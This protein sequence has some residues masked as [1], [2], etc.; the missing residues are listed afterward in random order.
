MPME[1]VVAAVLLGVALLT[2]L[3][4]I[5]VPGPVRLAP[6]RRRPVG[7][8]PPGVLTQVAEAT[9]NQVGALLR[10]RGRG[11]AALFER[12]G[13]RSRPQDVII[14]VACCTLVA[15]AA[16]LLLVHPLFGL[17]LA[18][19]TPIV[20]RLVIAARVT[21]RQA[22][23]ADQ[24]DETLVTLAGSLRAGYS[25]GQAATTIANDAE[26]PM[27]EEFRRAVNETRVGRPLPDALED[28]AV[29]T[30]NE[31][32]YWITQAIAINREVGGNLADVLEGVSETIR[33]RTRLRRQ[34]AALAA[35]GKMSAVVL[36]ILPFFIVVMLLVINPTY[37]LPLVTTLP[38]WLMVGGGLVLMV[39]GAFW[40]RAT[41]RIKF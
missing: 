28:I 6:Q 18:V 25:L 1:L 33:Q 38:G 35:E 41:T 21:R 27:A 39:I 4:L 15:F 7:A 40:L 29:R 3:V 5:L 19:L 23:F 13:I 26:I 37:L 16:G 22:A 30:R 20:A 2:C 34:V 9:S 10:G 36:F 24:L 14:V 8:A 17:L 32:F 31:D 11:T 12:A